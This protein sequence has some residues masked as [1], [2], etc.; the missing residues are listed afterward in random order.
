MVY[1]GAGGTASSFFPCH[2]THTLE[3]YKKLA[4]YWQVTLFGPM[5]IKR[6]KTR[7]A[8]ITVEDFAYKAE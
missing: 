1:K 8:T 3:T 2:D 7:D 5:A 6:I 4:H